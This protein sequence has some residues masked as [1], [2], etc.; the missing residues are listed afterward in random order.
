M[1]PRLAEEIRDVLRGK[2][3]LLREAA[4]DVPSGAV[5]SIT[6]R[7][8]TG[9]LS[10][11]DSASI[12]AAACVPQ[13]RLLPKPLCVERVTPWM[14]DGLQME[15]STRVDQLNSIH[16]RL[17]VS[18]F[19]ADTRVAIRGHEDP[20]RTPRNS[21]CRLPRL[22]LT[23]LPP[24]RPLFGHIARPTTRSAAPRCKATAPAHS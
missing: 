14:S 12:T 10:L 23:Q 24:R 17:S 5:A 20:H 3:A 6:H 13:E 19:D 11:C 1:P 22:K 8:N 15:A 7:N 16:S 2:V 4:T 21:P 9:D 18:P